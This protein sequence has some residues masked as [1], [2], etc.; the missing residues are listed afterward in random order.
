MAKPKTEITPANDNADPHDALAG[1]DVADDAD[2]LGEVD[3]SDYRDAVMT[4]N[5]KGQ[6]KSGRAIPVDM[7]YNTLDETTHSEIN[8]VF[9]LLH[10]SNLYSRFDNEAN[11]TEVICRSYDRVTG[12]MADGTTRPCSGCPDAVWYT[13][14][15]TGKRVC[16]CGPVYNVFGVNR[17]TSQGFVVRFKRSSLPVIKTHL[18]KH[19]LGRRV[20]K[21]KRSNYPLWAFPVKLSGKLAGPKATYAIPIIEKQDA[22]LTPDEIRLYAANTTAL[23]ERMH[24]VIARAEDVEARAEVDTSFDVDKMSAAEGQDFVESA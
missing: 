15:E 23:A 21:G 24:A 13:N 7:F 3:E 5:F 1:I 2:G 20:V 18:Q 10:K 12:T 11:K 16:N 6:D 4:L 19:H 17:D 14:A 9:C 8:A 22:P